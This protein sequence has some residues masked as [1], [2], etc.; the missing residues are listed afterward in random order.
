MRLPGTVTARSGS[1]EIQMTPMIDVVFLLLVFFVWTASFQMAEQLLPGSV[2]TASTAKP[3]GAGPA[4]LDEPPPPEADF[5]QLV[6]KIALRDGLPIW[7]VNEQEVASIGDVRRK[8]E[9]IA[10]ISRT[11]PVVLHPSGEVPLG[12][13]IDAYDAARLAGFSKVSFAASSK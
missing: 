11:A 3:A 4:T 13:V 2:S 10:S 9:R 7:V 5:D 6:V 1:M 8:L 12:H